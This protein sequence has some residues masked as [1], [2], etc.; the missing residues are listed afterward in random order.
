MLPMF[1]AGQVLAHG[2]TVAS[3]L[4]HHHSRDISSALEK[5]AKELFGGFLDA[6]TLDEDIQHLVILT[7]RPPEVV[8]FAMHDQTHLFQTPRVA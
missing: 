8:T 7:H 2:G 6:P 3:Q 1:D 4:I 5:L